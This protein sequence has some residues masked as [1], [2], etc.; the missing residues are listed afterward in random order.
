MVITDNV[1]VMRAAYAPYLEWMRDPAN[2]FVS[3]RLPYR[4]GTEMSVRLGEPAR[5]TPAQ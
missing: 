2:G 1:G 3:V 5:S 4:G